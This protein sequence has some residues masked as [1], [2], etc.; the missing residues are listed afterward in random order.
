MLD[1]I[2]YSVNI[3]ENSIKKD[4]CLCH[5]NMADMELLNQY[6][7]LINNKH[8]LLNKKLSNIYIKKIDNGKYSIR[9]VPQFISVS[10]FTGLSGIGYQ[11][12]RLYNS[13]KV[14]NVLTFELGK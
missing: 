14:S 4:D 1:E 10:L 3:I 7:K 8:D 5:G 6:I 13:D 9:Q 12:L 2:E 11:L